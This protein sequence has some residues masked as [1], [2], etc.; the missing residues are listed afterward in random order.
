MSYAS[1]CLWL[2]PSMSNTH[3]CCIHKCWLCRI[4]YELCLL[5]FSN[6]STYSWCTF[7]SF[8]HLSPVLSKA[9]V[10]I[11]ADIFLLMVWELF[12]LSLCL[13]V[14]LLGNWSYVGSTLENFIKPSSEWCTNL[15][16][17]TNAVWNN[18][19]LWSLRAMSWLGSHT[20]KLGF[21][22]SEMCISSEMCFSS[23]S[24]LSFLLPLPPPP[25]ILPPSM[26]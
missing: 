18:I 7:G 21:V 2:S 4:C 20:L 9:C 24:P 12:W 6:L 15:Q 19:P 13:E 14:E 11:P 10:S 17:Y 22:A 26:G 25:P 1:F 3:P 5:I 8:I 23:V 16:L